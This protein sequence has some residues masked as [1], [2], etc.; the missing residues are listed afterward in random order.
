M[1]FYWRYNIW[2]FM[3]LLVGFGFL[4]GERIVFKEEFVRFVLM[5]IENLKCIN[6]NFVVII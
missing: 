5:F 6:V 2:G 4:L 3:D 1:I